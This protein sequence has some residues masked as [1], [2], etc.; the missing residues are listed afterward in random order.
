MEEGA[1]QEKITAAV[2]L[3]RTLQLNP[4][5]S[6]LPVH[7]PWSFLLVQLLDFDNRIGVCAFVSIY[8]G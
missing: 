3:A 7:V 1:S 4:L 8:A 2:S 6:A 5:G